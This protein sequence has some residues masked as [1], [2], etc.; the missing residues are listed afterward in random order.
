MDFYCHG[1]ECTQYPQRSVACTEGCMSKLRQEG[2]VDG[3]LGVISAHGGEL[4][5]TLFTRT[6][7]RIAVVVGSEPYLLRALGAVGL[8]PPIRPLVKNRS[9]SELPL[10]RRKP[11]N[12]NP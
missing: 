6:R 8:A 3:V 11:S 9:G 7:N 10:I 1:A 4:S 2:G 12:G 5:L